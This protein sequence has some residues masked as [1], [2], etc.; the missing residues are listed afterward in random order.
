MSS[1]F[2]K[3]EVIKTAPK[4]TVL[5]WAVWACF[6]GV[7][8]LITAYKKLHE[9]YWKLKNES[10]TR[11]IE[12]EDEYWKLKEEFL[13]LKKESLKREKEHGELKEKHRVTKRK[14]GIL[15]EAAIQRALNATKDDPAARAIVNITCYLV[16]ADEEEE[17]EE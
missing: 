12:K 15:K 13:K 11:E 8:G 4:V 2:P 16:E 7:L 1:L 14:Y 10:L 3:M 5:A 17:E 9:E 6:F